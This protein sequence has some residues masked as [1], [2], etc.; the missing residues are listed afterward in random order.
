[1]KFFI[2]KQKTK[3]GTYYYFR[4]NYR[5]N[6]EVK[7]KQI[8]IGKE[9]DAL[10][11]ISDIYF[12][13]PEN[14]KLLS[15]S[16]EAILSK[17]AEQCNF[18]AIINQCVKNNARFKIGKFIRL[19][20][21]ERTLHNF[22][23]WKLAHKTHRTSFFSLDAEIPAKSFHESNIYH[24][25]D[26]IYPYIHAIQLTLLETIQSHFNLT[27]NELILDGTSFSCYGRDEGA[28]EESDEEAEEKSEVLQR[29]KG[30]S[31]DKRPKLPQINLLLGINCHYIPLVFET[32]SGNMPDVSMFEKALTLIQ[33]HYAP[34]LEAVR[35]RYLIFDRGNNNPANFNA[36]DALCQ[37]WGCYFVAGI[38]SKMVKQE[39]LALNEA[40]LALIYSQE[41]TT[42]IG[43]TIRKKLYEK[44]RLVLLYWNK[45][46]SAQKKDNYL[47]FLA[48]IE[49]QLTKISHKKVPADENLVEMQ[50]LLQKYHLKTSYSLEVKEGQVQFTRNPKKVEEKIALFGRYALITNNLSLSALAFIQIYKAKD[51]IEQE[52]HLL[53]SVFDLGPLFHYRPRRIKTHFAIV[54]WGILLCA[55]LKIVLQQHN[56]QWSFEELLDII[57]SG[58]LSIGTYSYP[59]SKQFKIERTLN[60]TPQLALLLKILHIPYEYSNLTVSPT[61]KKGSEVN[62]SRGSA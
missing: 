42:L 52:F 35:T 29:V 13:K 55:L 26:Y 15:Y 45:V 17:I 20:T 57:K 50:T 23:K 9:K 8:Y 2:K 41:K 62:N 27:F 19:L 28:D 14:E 60:I 1:M 10:K 5:Q 3:S 22:S 61:G 54:L 30:Y 38:R 24:Y 7:S 56:H 48:K 6:G 11:I 34:L 51:R 40:D 59:G 39:L 33:T 58:Q 12:K 49:H 16:G 37:K 44:D 47:Q 36:V 4:H 43:T 21:I 32:F 31:R 25:M 53:K 18:E 46:I